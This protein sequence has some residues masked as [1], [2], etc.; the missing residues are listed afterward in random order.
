MCAQY[1]I[2]DLNQVSLHKN[3][4]ENCGYTAKIRT[5]IEVINGMPLKIEHSCDIKVLA[6]HNN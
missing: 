6:H 1:L 4:V 3:F 2:Q 5:N